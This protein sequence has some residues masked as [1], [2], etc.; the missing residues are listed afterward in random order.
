MIKETLQNSIQ[1]SEEFPQ[2][3]FVVTSGASGEPEYDLRKIGESG[4]SLIQ[5]GKKGMYGLVLALVESEQEWKYQRVSLSSR[6]ED[7]NE[8]LQWRKDFHVELQRL[9]FEGF[10]IRAC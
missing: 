6:Y 8:V 5:I 2:F 3:K 4:N 10:G 9:G 7:S 1:I